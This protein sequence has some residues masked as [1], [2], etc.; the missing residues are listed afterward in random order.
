MEP[1]LTSDPGSVSSSLLQRVRL[2]DPEAWQRLVQLYGPQ[3]YLWA[4]QS[5]LQTQ[6]AADIVQEVLTAVATHI[7]GFRRDRPDESFRGWLW[8]ITRNKVRDHFRGLEGQAQAEGGTDAQRRLAQIPEHSADTSATS[9]HG[10]ADAALERRALELVRAKVED[11]TWQAF[12]RVTVDGRPVDEVAQELGMSGA[13]VYKSKY[14]VMRLVRN[15]LSD[16]LE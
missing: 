1:L 12:W 7:E 5:G 9:H 8:T 10:G 3:V 16:L 2:R 11:R 14:R 15:M 13:A 4:R 6:D